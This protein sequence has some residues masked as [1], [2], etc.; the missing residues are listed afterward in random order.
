MS[1]S[2]HVLDM[3]S[4]RPAVGLHVV[5]ESAA[6]DGHWQTVAEGVTNHEGRVADLLSR[7]GASGPHRIVF[8]TGNWAAGQGQVTFYPRVTIEFT[9]SDAVAHHHVPLLLGPFGYTTYRG[10]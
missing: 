10:S 5:L 8:D 7:Q 6:A 9:V 3:L 4:G 2:T 1:I